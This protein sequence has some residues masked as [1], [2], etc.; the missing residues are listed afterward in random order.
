MHVVSKDTAH[1]LAL[2]PAELEWSGISLAYIKH[3]RVFVSDAVIGMV[4]MAA[5]Q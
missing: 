4:V 2:L 5:E 1:S 3:I